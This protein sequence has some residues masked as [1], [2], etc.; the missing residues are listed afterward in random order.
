MIA[1]KTHLRQVL[2][3]ALLLPLFL[4][5]CGQPATE[6]KEPAASGPAPLW[7]DVR[8]PEEYEQQ[9]LEGA[10]NIPFD[11]ISG[12]PEITASP[13]DR[14]IHLY[15]R[16]GRRSG[17]AAAELRKMGYTRVLDRGGYANAKKIKA[18]NL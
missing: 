5:G 1:F 6:V 12:A 8:T 3:P 10:V 15:C 14:P 9:H 2:T 17:I 18:R 4:T 7:V 13:L 16:S 11:R